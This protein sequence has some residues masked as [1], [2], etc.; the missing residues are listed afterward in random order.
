MGKQNVQAKKVYREALKQN[1]YYIN[2]ACY[3]MPIREKSENIHGSTTV[4]SVFIY[5]RIC[6]K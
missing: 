3:V 2:S 5:L 4:K 6:A 1:I